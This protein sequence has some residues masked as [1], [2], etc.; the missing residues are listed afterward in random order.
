[1]VL[2]TVQRYCAACDLIWVSPYIAVEHFA[3]YR[4]FK[5]AK[6]LCRF[7]WLI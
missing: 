2:T 5:S 7:V 4:G 6:R 1:M 3:Q